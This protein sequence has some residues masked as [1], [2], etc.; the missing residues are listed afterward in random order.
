MV[1]KGRRQDWD[2]VVHNVHLL[3]L[4]I[5]LDAIYRCYVCIRVVVGVATHANMYIN[6]THNTHAV[7]S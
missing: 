3:T 5:K 7:A 4:C 1:K 2:G 6:C